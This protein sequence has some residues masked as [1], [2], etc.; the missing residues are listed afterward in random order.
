VRC[1]D[2]VHTHDWHLVCR[3]MLTLPTMTG[4]HEAFVAWSCAWC[5]LEIYSPATVHERYG[6][7][8]VGDFRGLWARPAARRWRR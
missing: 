1:T 5:G 8:T 7:I 3:L 4:W 6:A 2:D